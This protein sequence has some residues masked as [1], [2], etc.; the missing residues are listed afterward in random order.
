MTTI[1]DVD[2]VGRQS[3]GAEA[4]GRLLVVGN[5]VPDV[6]AVRGM[7]HSPMEAK[8]NRPEGY[9]KGQ[10]TPPETEG[11]GVQAGGCAPVDQSAEGVL[12]SLPRPCVMKNWTS[13][14]PRMGRGRR[15][16]TQRQPSTQRQA[17]ALAATFFI[18]RNEG[19]SMLPD[20]YSC[21]HRIK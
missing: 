1:L 15:P 6:L 16:N 17:L 14:A 21:I 11:Q 13:G 20:N 5:K 19:S 7:G 10:T 4:P 3:P 8:R 18:A 12:A 2:Q 9:P